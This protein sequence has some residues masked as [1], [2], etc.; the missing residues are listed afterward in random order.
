MVFFGARGAL[1]ACVFHLGEAQM[2]IVPCETNADCGEKEFCNGDANVV[3]GAKWYPGACEGC[4]YPGDMS[5]CDEHCTRYED[6][7]CNGGEWC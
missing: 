2:K 4:Y 7:C 3:D 1:V 5:N 6:A